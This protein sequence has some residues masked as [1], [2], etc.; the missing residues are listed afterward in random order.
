MTYLSHKRHSILKTVKLYQCVSPHSILMNIRNGTTMTIIRQINLVCGNLRKLL[1]H[2][3]YKGSCVLDAN[4]YV[5]NMLFRRVLLKYSPLIR[6]VFTKLP[7]YL[8]TR[9]IFDRCCHSG[10]NRCF[11]K[12][13]LLLTNVALT[14]FDHVSIM[15]WKESG[16]RLWKFE[17]YAILLI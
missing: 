11:Y 5:I 14:R 2:N 3:K 12:R 1:R 7:Y 15:N 16:L 13:K 17:Q 9:F 8:P 6:F 10:S 4:V